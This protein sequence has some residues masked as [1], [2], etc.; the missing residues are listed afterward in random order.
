M[1]RAII[2]KLELPICSNGAQFAVHILQLPILVGRRVS[3]LLSATFLQRQSSA[4][5]SFPFLRSSTLQDSP[6]AQKYSN[7]CPCPALQQCPSKQ[8]SDPLTDDSRTASEH[9]SG[10]TLVNNDPNWWNQQ[11]FYFSYNNCDNIKIIA[12]HRHDIIQRTFRQL[13]QHC[14]SSILH[15]YIT[16]STDHYTWSRTLHLYIGLNEGHYYAVIVCTIRIAL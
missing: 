1:I 3:F 11:L 6:E 5:I 15:K 7:P 4:L 2:N 10:W 14:T 8:M 9:V 12:L 16:W 13:L